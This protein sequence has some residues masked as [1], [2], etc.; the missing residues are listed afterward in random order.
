MNIPRLKKRVK[1]VVDLIRPF[2]LLAP[3]IVS[4]CIMIASFFHNGKTDDLFL[5]LI[6]TII[7]ASFSLA[8]LNSASN[9]LNQLTDV[10]TD[11]I[12]KPYRPIPT[13]IITILEAKIISIILY[14]L[15]FSLALYVG[16]I[17][18]VFILLITLF[19]IT[20]SLPPKL[21]NH[22]FLNQIW[23]AVP[24]GLL[25]ILASWSVFGNPLESL[26]LSIA[27]IAMLFLIGGSSTKDI[28]DSDADK[29][30]GVHTLVNTFG[31]KKAALLSLPFMF[32]PFVIIPILVNNGVLNESLM[33]LTFLA[34]PGFFVFRLMFE[35]K[36]SRFF[37]NTPAWTLM[38]TTYFVF[39]FGF[40]F[41]TIIA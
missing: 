28:L 12:S 29:K 16:F 37:E 9:T 27:L 23:V 14:L 10:E 6:K 31:V 34:I 25:G 20:Y 18:T 22:L 26:P 33:F 41:L 19:T 2:T 11:K 21:K 24:R 32:F 38:Y 8:L 35:E 1:G 40:S 7:P 3:V 36:R 4:T 30:T 15:S 5:M 13:G 39:A 17:F